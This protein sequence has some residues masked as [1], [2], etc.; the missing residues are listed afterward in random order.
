MPTTFYIFRSSKRQDQYKSVL[1]IGTFETTEEVAEFVNKN[2]ET[3]PIHGDKIYIVPKKYVE[4]F[5][6]VGKP[7]LVK[8]KVAV[9]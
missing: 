8:S 3:N 6:F 5:E 1:E 4:V 9:Q 7:L 2:I